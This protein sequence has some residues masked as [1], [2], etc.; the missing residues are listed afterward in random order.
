MRNNNYTEIEK[1]LMDLLN[2]L[3]DIFNEDEIQ[4]VKEFIDVGEYGLALDTLID[5]IVEEKKQVSENVLEI[6]Y[7]L[8]RIMS[9]DEKTIQERIM[10][11]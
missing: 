5:I 2:L 1:L 4:E 8:A 6:I 10:H 3:T 9:L 11:Q 7:K